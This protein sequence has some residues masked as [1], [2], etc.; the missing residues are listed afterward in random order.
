[1]QNPKSFPSVTTLDCHGSSQAPIISHQDVITPSPSPHWS[2]CIYSAP[3]CPHH[4]SRHHLSLPNSSQGSQNADLMLSSFAEN[5]S[6]ALRDFQHESSPETTRFC[7][8]WLALK[9]DSLTS[10]HCWLPSVPRTCPVPS[11]SRFPTCC[12]SY[13]NTFLYAS[14]SQTL[15]TLGI[16]AQ[17]SLPWRSWPCPALTE[18]KSS[19]E[20]SSSSHSVLPGPLCLYLIGRCLSFPKTLSAMMAGTESGFASCNHCACHQW[21]LKKHLFKGFPWRFSG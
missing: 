21:V 6:E 19:A 11:W 4:P 2:P 12:F 17:E 8:V 13:R 16:L 20:N 18:F 15:I 10:Q 14:P 1:M 3:L 9:L 7:W 5:S